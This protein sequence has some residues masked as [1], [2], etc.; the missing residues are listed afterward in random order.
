MTKALFKMQMKSLMSSMAFSKRIQGRTTSPA[1]GVALYIFIMGAIAAAIYFAIRMALASTMAPLLLTDYGWI[2]F[3]MNAI[4]GAVI[5]FITCVFLADNMIFRPKDNDILLP[6]PIQPSKIVMVRMTI[7]AFRV[8]FFTAIGFVP[9]IDIYICTM[10]FDPL[11]FLFQILT[12][13][14]IAFFTV[15]IC[16]IVGFITSKISS[17]IG[18]GTG[19]TTITVIISFA[20]MI[21]YML[22][23]TKLQ[24][25]ITYII[26]HGQDLG[27][28]LMRYLYPFYLMGR[29]CLGDPASL[30]IILLVTAAV[31]L[32]IWFIVQRNFFSIATATGHV[33]RKIY[34]GGGMVAR[35]ASST[36]YR[37][38]L[39]RL[40]SSAVYIMNSCANIL[41]TIIVGVI[42]LVKKDAIYTVFGRVSPVTQSALF[43]MIAAFLCLMTAMGIM[44]ASSVSLEG[45]SLWILKTLPVSSKSILK[46]KL[47]LQLSVYILPL[48]FISFVM[49]YVFRPSILDAVLLFV[50]ILLCEVFIAEVG[51]IE[52]LKRP[53]FDWK[54]EAI[55]IKQ[56]AAVGFSMLISGV[57]PVAIFVPYVV[58]LS[59]LFNGGL[60]IITGSVYFIIAI[61]IYLVLD[62]LLYYWIMTKG[63]RKFDEM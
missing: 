25:L 37:K 42:L 60:V 34:H 38:E 5:G 58:F 16:L 2:Y 3:A 41:F 10:G 17:K 55:V 11:T 29:G 12:L 32:L 48:L 9:S 44:T 39:K 52:N 59:G 23:V 14:S 20:L 8:L 7:L 1:A 51:L 47:K 33:K 36:L 40:S 46:A 43:V 22:A 35:S 54:N 24:D 63:V 6:L 26:T 56:S 19:K 45:S 50:L 13:F 49:V 31:F 4:V 21:V 53:R 62:I 18:A 57:V 15:S 61:A 28:D 27:E 30:L